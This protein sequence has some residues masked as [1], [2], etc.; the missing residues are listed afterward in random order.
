MSAR[1]HKET[2]RRGNIHVVVDTK[3]RAQAIDFICLKKKA[4]GVGRF[5]RLTHQHQS[6]RAEYVYV[7]DFDRLFSHRMFLALYVTVC[8]CVCLCSM[9]THY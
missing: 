2:H 7:F 9:C 6:E 4:H 3:H 5:S 8:V 1:K